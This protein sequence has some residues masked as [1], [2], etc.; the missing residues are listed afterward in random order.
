MVTFGTA[1]VRKRLRIPVRCCPGGHIRLLFETP[2][3]ATDHG[4]GKRRSVI[5]LSQNRAVRFYRRFAPTGLACCVFLTCAAGLY[6]IL[7][8]RARHSDLIWASASSKCFGLPPPIPPSPIGPNIL[9]ANFIFGVMT[10]S[11]TD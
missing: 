11:T 3:S 7:S 10:G 5:L 2:C 8:Y 6:R 4:G 1:E 9:A